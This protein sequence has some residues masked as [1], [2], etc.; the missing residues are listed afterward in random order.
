MLTPIYI[1]I[2]V[3]AIAVLMLLLVIFTYLIRK[4]YVPIRRLTKVAEAIS[5][6]NIETAI[7]YSPDASGEI[8]LMSGAL[9]TMVE[10]FRVNTMKMEQTQQEA[11]IKLHIEQVITASGSMDDVFG[12]FAKMLCEYF[13]IH[14]TTIVFLNADKA[15]AFTN[16]TSG[17]EFLEHEHTG[18]LLE[19]RRIVFLNQ[20]SI[21]SNNIGFTEPNTKAVCL[22][23]L[24]N[25]DN[26]LGYIIFE[27]NSK[28]PL[29]EGIEAIMIYLSEILSEWLLVK[30]WNYNAPAYEPEYLPVKAQTQYSPPSVISRLKQIEGLA[31]DFA[32]ERM[33]G[34]T[35]AYEKTVR[36]LAR[37]LPE[38]IE[39]MD[40]HISEKDTNKFMV[41]V[42]GVKGTL[43]NIGAVNLGN[44]AANLEKAAQEDEGDY[45][46]NNY[47]SFKESLLEF[48]QQLNSVFE[49]DKAAPGRAIGKDA[50]FAAVT[51]AKAAAKGYDAV[52][53][54]EKLA[55]LTG[56][57][58]NKEV[59]ELLNKIIFALEE[60]NCGRALE[61][62][63]KMEEIL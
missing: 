39:K 49:P 52:L 18:A 32:L 25:G 59:D 48:L 37:L 53:A 47:P 6:G 43:R 23:P 27:N 22:V 41:E 16:N 9:H 1:I 8:G 14:K 42:H 17:H 15:T 56:C 44:V 13:N 45:C 35:E 40:K 36:L 3:T 50:V 46:D 62:I 38:T 10:Q 19:G 61:D 7:G 28:K 60:F 29:T 33:G 11:F 24:R 54:L 2:S 30:D 31:V 5:K 55:P 34:L 26:L 12:G 20:Q 57:L 58:C 4:I 63:I 21:S 51:Q